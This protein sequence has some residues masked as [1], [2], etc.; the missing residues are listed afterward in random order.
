MTAIDHDRD[1]IRTAVAA[2]SEPMR[3]VFTLHAAGELDYSTIGF[4]LGITLS[5]VETLLAAA[6]VELDRSLANPPDG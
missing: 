4:R 6:I 5:E 2:L 1:R 3:S